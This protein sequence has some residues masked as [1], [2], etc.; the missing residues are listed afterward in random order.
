[1]GAAYVP[2]DIDQGED[3]TGNVIYTDD[4]DQPYN[5]VAPCRLDIKNATGATQL[6]LTTPDIDPVPDGTI[7]EIG[8]SS[9]EGLIQIHIDDQV[10]GA[11][12]PGVYKYDLF[13]TVNDGSEY[14]GN[15]V[16]R[17]IRGEVTV[18][19]RVTVL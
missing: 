18:N 4:M 13:V 19:Q 3:W 6:S 17:L 16:Q 11:L 2:L 7:P 1:M 12:V 15:Q 10:T 14:A 5:V 9:E 8:L